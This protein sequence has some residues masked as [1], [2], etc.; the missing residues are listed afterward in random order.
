MNDAT[1][2][3]STLSSL[4]LDLLAAKR[5]A[6]K[7]GTATTEELALAVGYPL[8]QV[9]DRAYWLAKREGKLTMIGSGKGA[10][11]RAVPMSRKAA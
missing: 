8:K 3:K 7:T 11:W 5:K 2:T 10:V 4:I 6:H 9:Y 1:A